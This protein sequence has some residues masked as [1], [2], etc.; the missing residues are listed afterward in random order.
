MKMHQLAKGDEAVKVLKRIF[1]QQISGVDW[2]ELSKPEKAIAEDI[3][4]FFFAYGT[5][6][7]RAQI[8]SMWP[9]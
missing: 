8:E 6:D 9:K 1:R 4:S 7:E 5:S 3:R 2:D